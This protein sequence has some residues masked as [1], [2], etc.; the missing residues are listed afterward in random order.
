M[1]VQVYN[2]YDVYVIHL[3][4]VYMCGICMRIMYVCGYMCVIYCNIYD[5]CAMFIHV[6]DVYVHVYDVHVIVYVC[7]WV[8]S[9]QWMVVPQCQRN[10]WSWPLTRAWTWGT[11]T[12]RCP[13]NWAMKAWRRLRRT[14]TSCST[15]ASQPPAPTTSPSSAHL[16]FPLVTSRSVAGCRVW[17]LAKVSDGEREST[18]QV[19][20]LLRPYCNNNSTFVTTDS[21][22]VIQPV[23][24]VQFS[25]VP[26]SLMEF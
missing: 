3:M 5:V 22:H 2:V 25:H 16:R 6:Y 17:K 7:R 9:K 12:S 8:W 19:S 24:H 14:S 11:R 18:W 21:S 15:T 13:T 10:A 26:Q 23:Y 4:Y 20:G 1:C